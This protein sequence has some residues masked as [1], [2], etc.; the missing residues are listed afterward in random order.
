MTT[1]IAV[2]GGLRISIGYP[3]VT[4]SNTRL[5]SSVIKPSN[6]NNLR[7]LLVYSRHT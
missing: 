3:C 1:K 7:I 6:C 2:H 5:P 4:E